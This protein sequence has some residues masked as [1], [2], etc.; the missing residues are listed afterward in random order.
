LNFSF[1]QERDP[2][3]GSVALLKMFSGDSSSLM[4]ATKLS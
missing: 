3:K 1:F 2:V 4:P